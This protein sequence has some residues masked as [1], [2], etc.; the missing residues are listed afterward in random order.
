MK[1][2]N[3]KNRGEGSNRGFTLVELLVVIAIIGVLIALLLPAVQA[4]REAA[5]RAQ[6]SNNLKQVGL[7]IHNFHDVHQALP[8]SN[9]YDGNHVTLWV[10]IYPFIEQQS[11]WEFFSRDE[12][13]Y[14]SGSEL[15]K[16][17]KKLY[18]AGDL[19]HWPAPTGYSDE[20]RNAMG[21]I[22]MYHCPARRGGGVHISS[23]GDFSLG[24]ISGPQIDYAFV[25]SST[26]TTDD[27][28]AD[29]AWWSMGHTYAY[30]DGR[31]LDSYM[32]GPFRRASAQGGDST[33]Y[34]SIDN[35]YY[36]D[37]T[38]QVRSGNFALKM[39]FASIT[40]GLSNQILIGE[41]HIPLGRLNTC[42]SSDGWL[43]CFADCSYLTNTGH[44]AAGPMRYVWTA[45]RTSSILRPNDY[46]PGDPKTA[47]G[48]ILESGGFGSWH[49]MV[50]Q[51]L[52][53]DG[54]VR[55]LSVTTPVGTVL[56][57]LSFIDDGAVVQ[58][59]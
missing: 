35:C 56:G 27:S 45:G 49:P 42:D 31:V 11:L 7:A 4:A 20:M 9:F 55:A 19:W 22:G 38:D 18:H 36:Y 12:K 33:S 29:I 25:F 43:W 26:T 47:S 32:H 52:L 8:P 37:M 58:L 13:I 28:T 44:A 3:A 23:M 40:D 6:C 24:S 2:Q 15:L 10:F 54:S 21:S 41:K 17:G 5:R 30:G 14:D 53:G 34:N 39:T 1:N 48:N 59:P 51:F 46:S 50:C 16:P 57:P